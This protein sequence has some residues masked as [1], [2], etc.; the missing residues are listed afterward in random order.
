M[1]SYVLDSSAVLALLNRET[2]ND[3]VAE[4]IPFGMI[5]AVS[6]AEVLTRSIDLGQPYHVALSSFEYLRLPVVS[7]DLEQGAKAA[8]LRSST[9]HLGLSLGDRSCLALALLRGATAI[10][11]DQNWKH[12]NVCPVEM[13]R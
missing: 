6:M 10:T 1:S 8:E 5:S 12:I 7:F 9:K 13:I 3:R 11:A 4:C 2:G